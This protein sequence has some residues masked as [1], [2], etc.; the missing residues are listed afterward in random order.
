MHDLPRGYG[1]QHTQRDNALPPRE[2]LETD[3]PL[4]TGQRVRQDQHLGRQD[5]SRPRRPLVFE[6]ASS[7]RS[8]PAIW[9]GE[10]GGSRSGQ[11]SAGWPARSCA[12]RRRCPT[13]L[14]PE[15]AP[16]SD[17]RCST[18]QPRE[19]KSAAATTSAGCHAPITF[20]SSGRL[21][22]DVV[23]LQLPVVRLMTGAVRSFP[24]NFTM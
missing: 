15:Y 21:L 18:T 11:S 19:V 16:V 3:G 12:P 10:V 2:P 1:F 13:Q 8:P 14:K 24:L 22:I 17:P 23:A 7:P 5:V 6:Y 4:G 20:D 9:H